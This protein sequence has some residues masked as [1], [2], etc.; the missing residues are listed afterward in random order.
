M[1]RRQPNS[2]FSDRCLL[3]S[4]PDLPSGR[5]FT[6]A[7]L[8]MRFPARSRPSLSFLALLALTPLA[9][10]DAA[11][12]GDALRPGS[13]VRLTA[14]GVVAGQATA[15][16]VRQTADS[17]TIARQD[18]PPITIATARVTSLEVSRGRSRSAG[19]ARGVLWSLPVGVAGGI[20]AETAFRRCRTCG[21]A[22]NLTPF[23]AALLLGAL[24][25]AGIGAVIGR[26]RWESLELH[27]AMTITPTA[28]R[29]G[30]ELRWAM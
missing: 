10:R 19:A 4:D 18:T 11:A 20:V 6:L 3:R 29:P 17:L 28:G 2:R 26:E 5:A 14:P 8:P 12:Q 13:R 30:I 21:S 1:S 15:T 25:G 27:H 16:I 9:A 22:E 7:R 24:G 23:H